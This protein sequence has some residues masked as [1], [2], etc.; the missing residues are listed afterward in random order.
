MRKENCAS[1]E[2]LR[3]VSGEHGDHRSRLIVLVL[4]AGF[5]LGF[6]M[7]L[8]TGASWLD[9]D[10]QTQP[11]VSGDPGL[12]T[13]SGLTLASTGLADFHALESSEPR[14]EKADASK[15]NSPSKFLS[16]LSDAQLSE[17][18]QGGQRAKDLQGLWKLKQP[19]WDQLM[20]GELQRRWSQQHGPTE[21][22][23]SPTEKS[24][25]S[26]EVV[27]GEQAIDQQSPEKRSLD[28]AGTLSTDQRSAAANTE[29]G[30]A[31]TNDTP[32][33]FVVQQV[34]TELV[35]GDPL[36]PGRIELTFQDGHGP[37]IYPDQ[38]V[39]I[40]SQDERIFYVTT[41]LTYQE[42]K[43]RGPYQVKKLGGWFL[44]KD[45][46]PV[47]VEVSIADATLATET[48]DD[49]RDDRFRRRSCSRSHLCR[50][51]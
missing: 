14:Q 33:E 17:L 21:A 37:V 36:N 16:G 31:T 28:Q 34:L 42:T 23:A 2:N 45:E 9:V 26:Q 10:R 46:A 13:S 27:A 35:A 39:V 48:I 22:E 24:T 32:A 11:P 44:I 29:T 30:V 3:A 49:L 18:I 7:M 4:L 41:Q 47:T 6:L 50:S 19:E 5:G 8:S 20:L 43:D 1:S 51:G 12:A 40:Q 15:P 25:A 38:S